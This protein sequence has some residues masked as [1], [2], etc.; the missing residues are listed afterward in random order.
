MRDGGG[1][2]RGKL[3]YFHRVK[4]LVGGRGESLTLTINVSHT[5]LLV[6][7]RRIQFLL[8][9][10][11]RRYGSHFWPKGERGGGE[12]EIKLIWAKPGIALYLLC[13]IILLKM[14]FNRYR[15]E[16]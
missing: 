3:L 8:I 2:G 16:F 7:K 4:V 6:L 1:K 14:F 15:T 5:P 11:W 9:T 10:N 12:R 13:N